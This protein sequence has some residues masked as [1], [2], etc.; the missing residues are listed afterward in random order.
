MTTAPPSVTYYSGWRNVP[1]FA[2][3]SAQLEKN[4]RNYS[5][6]WA[7]NKSP[8]TLSFCSDRGG[9]RETRFSLVDPINYPADE[10][11]IDLLLLLL[12]HYA[13]NISDWKNSSFNLLLPTFG[14]SQQH[15]DSNLRRSRFSFSHFH[16]LLSFFLRQAPFALSFSVECLLPILRGR[17]ASTRTQSPFIRQTRM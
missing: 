4:P 16:R 11:L 1:L 2:A 8:T 9:S 6:L 12:L 7:A 10:T 3:F 14:H 15:R 17:R 5:A 13:P